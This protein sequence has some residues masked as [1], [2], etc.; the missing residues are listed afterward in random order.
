MQY[1]DALKLWG[2][3]RLADKFATWNPEAVIDPE[4]VKVSMYFN[5]G[6]PCCGGRDPNCYCS[7]AESPK[8]EVHITGWEAGKPRRGRDA[9]L[10]YTVRIDYDDFDFVKV[11]GEILEVADGEVT[12]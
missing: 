7:M 11:L 10:C 3:K 1:E 5:E 12:S 2:L 8:A 6:Y 9:G 4:S